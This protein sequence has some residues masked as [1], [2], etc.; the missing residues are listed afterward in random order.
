M[1]ISQDI[2]S[3]MTPED[4]EQLTAMVSELE[5][6]RGGAREVDMV[7][8]QTGTVSRNM[9]GGGF[10]PKVANALSFALRGKTMDT[11]DD[12]AEKINALIATEK[13]KEHMASQTPEGRLK[14]R[15]A[16]IALG[17]AP[18]VGE[19]T[20]PITTMPSA[21]TQTTQTGPQTY[22]RV[23]KGPNKY[24]V[25]EYDYKLSPESEAAAAGLKTK[26]TKGAEQEAA[27]KPALNI[28]R[29]LKQD[30]LRAFPEAPIIGEGT[31][32]FE[33]GARKSWEAFTQEDPEAAAYLNTRKAYLS[34]LVRGLGEKGVLT[35]PDIERVASAIGSQWDTKTVAV[36]QFDRLEKLLSA[37]MQ[38][39]IDSGGD[40]SVIQEVVNSI[41]MQST[42]G[43]TSKSGIS[44]SGIR[45]TVTED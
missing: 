36:D 41:D 42:P 21:T 31:S 34:L 29:T 37:D 8:P 13:L 1:P 35:N 26:A 23:P 39:Y 5:R 25:M 10:L 40:P 24:G 18:I 20:A 43:R 14:R 19:E 44:K 45:Y 4:R 7:Q 32:R 6:R 22:I 27:M 3:K 9:G 38:N 33:H 12:M 30:W 11:G 15:E 17:E 16:E 28:V 2:L